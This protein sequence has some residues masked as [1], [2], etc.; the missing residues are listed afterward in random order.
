[1]WETTASDVV[2]ICE[3]GNGALL[4][5]V[6]VP[7]NPVVVEALAVKERAGDNISGESMIQTQRVNVMLASLLIPTAFG[8]TNNV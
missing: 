6:S 1:M 3:H 7:E 4:G 2:R 8:M 5:V